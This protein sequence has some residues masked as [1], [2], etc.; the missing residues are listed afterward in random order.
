MDHVDM[1]DD[2]LLYSV[3]SLLVD[4]IRA[5]PPTVTSPLK[6]DELLINS[7]FKMNQ[8]IVRDGPAEEI[9]LF[10]PQ[11]EWKETNRHV[12]LIRHFVSNY[13]AD[14]EKRRLRHE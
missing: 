13:A 8:T 14:R 6:E 5:G 7:G 10:V 1:A 2:G 11:P 12:P 3:Q 9:L 4:Y